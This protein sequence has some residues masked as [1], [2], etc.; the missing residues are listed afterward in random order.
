MSGQPY[1]A[2]KSELEALDFQVE[3][4][5]EAD[6]V[7]PSGDVIAQDPGGGTLAP[8]GT[9]ITL[10]VSLGKE[11]VTMPALG[12]YTFEDAQNL[13]ERVKTLE[14]DALNAPSRAAALWC[15]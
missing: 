13:L 11:T 6:D 3:K 14:P 7:V 4:V 10:T 2:A 12:S 5:E 15:Q 1:E 8:A 9:T